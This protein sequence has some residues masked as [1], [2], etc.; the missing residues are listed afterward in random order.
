MVITN[1]GSQTFD[2]IGYLITMP[3]KVHYNLENLSTLLS[4]KD[5]SAIPGVRITIDTDQENDFT[6]SIGTD[7]SFKFFQCENAYIMLIQVL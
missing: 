6:V 3:I 5:V 2:K 7:I 1:G 4:F